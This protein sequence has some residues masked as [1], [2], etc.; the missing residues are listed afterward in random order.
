MYFPSKTL[1]NQFSVFINGMQRQANLCYW[2]MQ[3]EL[4][5]IRNPEKSQVTTE[6]GMRKRLTRFST[7]QVV[8][9]STCVVL[10][11]ATVRADTVSWTIKNW[12]TH[13]R[14]A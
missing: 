7:I 5:G 1:E 2:L 3:Q 6:N 13:R 9:G 14:S 4:N 8:S 10:T 12:L 11:N